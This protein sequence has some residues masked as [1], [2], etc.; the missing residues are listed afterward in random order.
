MSLRPRVV[1][2][3]VCC[4]VSSLWLSAKKPL[5]TMLDLRVLWPPLA[6]GLG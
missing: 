6:L 5:G 2:K 4:V 1:M 3:R